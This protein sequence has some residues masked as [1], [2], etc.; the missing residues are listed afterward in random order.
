[1]KNLILIF[2]FLILIAEINAQDSISW[3]VDFVT[4]SA[5]ESPLF[6]GGSISTSLSK[7]RMVILADFNDACG[8]F[9]Y[10]YPL[11]KNLSVGYSGGVFLKRF[12][13]GPVLASNFFKG[14]LTSLHWFGGSFGDTES[15]EKSLKHQFCFSYQ[16]ISLKFNPLTGYYVLMHYQ[17]N[18]PEHIMG[19]RGEYKIF[20]R[21]FSIFEQVS[22]IL[23]GGYMLKKD[24]VI[25]STGIRFDL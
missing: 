8:Q 21:K 10:L 5:G 20:K 16:Q 7:E 6:T 17:D 22:L 24:K 25:G 15:S 4:F 11:I 13:H 3:K 9:V 2:A 23:E 1:M 14:H 12:W 18:A 19:I